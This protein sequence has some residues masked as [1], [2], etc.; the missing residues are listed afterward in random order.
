MTKT[1][2]MTIEQYVAITEWC[3]HNK[4]R[5]EDLGW[6]Q[7]RTAQE[8]AAVFQFAVPLSSLQRCAKLAKIQWANSPL[9]PPP[10]PI[11]REA[12]VILIGALCGIYIETD[13]TV[14]ENLAALKRQY[15][16]EGEAPTKVE[17]KI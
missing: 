3:K 16:S 13:R 4:D 2:R 9:S 6:T 10:V 5:I 8:A 17:V 14:P 11:D 12:I 1:Q 7:L 15:V